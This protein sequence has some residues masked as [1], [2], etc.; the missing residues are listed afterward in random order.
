MSIH[1]NRGQYENVLKDKKERSEPVLNHRLMPFFPSEHYIFES[2]NPDDIVIKHSVSPFLK[3]V[4][5]IAKEKMKKE[6]KQPL[7]SII[8]APGLS[9]LNNK[10]SIENFSVED[11]FPIIENLPDNWKNYFTEEEKKSGIYLND[12]KREKKLLSTPPPYQQSC[13]S[14]YAFSVANAISDVLLFSNLSFNPNISPM[15]ILSCIKIE[16]NSGCNGGN[17]MATLQYIAN[18]GVLTS[19]CINYQEFLNNNVYTQPSVGT[20][21][22]TSTSLEVD[23]IG[24]MKYNTTVSQLDNGWDYTVIDMNK[25]STRTDK[26]D[27]S[28]SYKTPIIDNNSNF[29]IPDCNCYKNNVNNEDSHYNYFITSP[30]N[31]VIDEIPDAVQRIKSHLY[32]YGSA[33]SSFMLFSNFIEDG[34]NFKDTKGIYFESEPYQ[35]SVFTNTYDYNGNPVYSLQP[36]N[37]PYKQCGGHA[38]VV[39]GWGVENSPIT[40]RNGTIVQKTPYWICRNSWSDSW[41]DNGYFKIAMYQKIGIF[42]INPKSCL[43]KYKDFVDGGV[44]YR[45]QGGIIL[46]K[47]S[48]NY[49][50]Y[51]GNYQLGNKNNTYYSN[52]PSPYSKSSPMSEVPYQPPPPPVRGRNSYSIDEK[53][54]LQQQQQQSNDTYFNKRNL[55]IFACLAVFVLFLLM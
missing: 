4:S 42:E 10:T 17:A 52:E 36:V 18:N 33:V 14:C 50:K 51:N 47:P 45:K 21:G 22:K 37:D 31:F 55:I 3:P 25:F 39:V 26:S 53:R 29:F 54:Q 2:D 34:T 12:R 48:S 9:G 7:D 43:E 1:F 20:I 38:I 49:S 5:E 6:N 41:G 46:F 16:D 13:G 40:L 30:T 35:K 24:N 28:Y 8:I 32:K 15:C 11:D 44:T 27:G 23:L 19:H